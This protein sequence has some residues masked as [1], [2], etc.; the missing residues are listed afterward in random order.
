MAV[1]ELTSNQKHIVDVL[2]K[3]N[4]ALNREILE[5]ASVFIA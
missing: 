2:I 5:N 3:T 1:Q 4:P